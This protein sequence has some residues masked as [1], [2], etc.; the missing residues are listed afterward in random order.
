MKK[1]VTD[2]FLILSN[3]IT[4]N[5]SFKIPVKYKGE[6]LNFPAMLLVYGYSYKIQVNVAGLE[7]LF[8]PDEERNYRAVIDPE[9]LEGTKKLSVE[10]LKAIA[11]AI[12]AIVK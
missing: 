4:L 9:K 2:V 10:L 1:Q 11:E 12:E 6:D 3:L 7:V 5:D 8:E